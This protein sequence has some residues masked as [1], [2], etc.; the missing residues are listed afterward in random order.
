[1]ALKDDEHLTVEKLGKEPFA[2]MMVM[3]AFDG[4]MA[5]WDLED[6]TERQLFN[7]LELGQGVVAIPNLGSPS[8]H[9]IKAYCRH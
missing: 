4:V 9:V 2:D 8:D 5:K 3:R 7:K 1:M 6:I